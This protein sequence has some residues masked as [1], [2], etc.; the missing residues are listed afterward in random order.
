MRPTSTFFALTCLL[1][2]VDGLVP[3]IAGAQDGPPLN[4]WIIIEGDPDLA[5]DLAC[6]HDASA[7]GLD[8]TDEAV[9]RAIESDCQIRRLEAEPSGR[10]ELSA[11]K[12]RTDL[13]PMIYASA[14][15]QRRLEKMYEARRRAWAARGI[16]RPVLSVNGDLPL[17]Y[18]F[19]VTEAG[20]DVAYQ[21][22]TVEARGSASVN[23][24]K[25]E[26]AFAENSRDAVSGSVKKAR[27]R[28]E[29]PI[30]F[31]PVRM[32]A[33]VDTY[34]VRDTTAGSNQKRIGRG[35]DLR[36][37]KDLSDNIE[38]ELS[39]KLEYVKDGSSRVNALATGTMHYDFTIG[40][41]LGRV[42]PGAE[43]SQT[44]GSG[45]D[46]PVSMALRVRFALTRGPQRL[47]FTQRLYR[48]QI[49]GSGHAGEENSQ[50]AISYGYSWPHS[51]VA[52]RG[53]HLTNTRGGHIDGEDWQIG[54]IWTLKLE[55]L[56]DYVR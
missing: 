14:A 54:A 13:L 53:A 33:G 46:S 41:W 24:Y 20:G 47:E 1:A 38:T 6:L 40:D 12:F 43:L 51:T 22:G 34:S 42:S 2:T 21:R 28:G 11:L 35:I 25:L 27:L 48:K 39:G 19:S 50:T 36:I 18:S 55:A 17:S 8:E 32:H 52:L 30:T 31:G 10:E 23:D 3:S 7:A 16:K 49:M 45:G 5:P 56:A 4:S 37:N 44:T 9:V 29:V 15:E 26:G